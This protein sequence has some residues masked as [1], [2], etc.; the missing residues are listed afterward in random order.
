MFEVPL[1]DLARK[2][3]FKRYV[4]CAFL[5][6]VS[7]LVPSVIPN[8]VQQLLRLPLGFCKGYRC[9]QM[10]EKKKIFEDPE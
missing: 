7:T 4:H 5:N 10:K 9:T 3:A 6:I 2:V 8:T 1:K